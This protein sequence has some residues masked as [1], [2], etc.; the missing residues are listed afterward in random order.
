MPSDP[1]IASFLAEADK[2]IAFLHSEYSKVQTGRASATI[3]EHVEVEAYGVKQP[4]KAVAGIAIEDAR[5]IM[6]QPW[7]RSI[8]A[9]VE[10]AIVK[11]DLGTNPVNDGSGIRIVLPPMT[12]ERRA[13]LK[14]HVHQLAEEARI[15]IRHNRQTAQEIIKKEAD[16]DVR[17][18]LLEELESSVK[19]SNETIEKIMKEKEHEVMTV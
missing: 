4:L 9:A 5:T 17:F 6:V 8:I 11:A 1:R 3:I 7:D 2:V 19:K 16:E 10:R 15:S 14:K 13:S 18:S 12:E